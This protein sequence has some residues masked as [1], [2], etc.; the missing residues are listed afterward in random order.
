MKKICVLFIVAAINAFKAWASEIEDGVVVLTDLN[1]DEQ[2]EKNDNVL[3]E[4]YAPW[5]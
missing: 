1:F 5:W 4:F 3:V 2:I